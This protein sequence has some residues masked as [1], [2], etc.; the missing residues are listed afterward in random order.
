MSSL[1]RRHEILL[2]PRFKEDGQGVPFFTDRR[3]PGRGAERYYVLIA[4]IGVRRI[5]PGTLLQSFFQTI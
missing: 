1:L 2:S 4:S 5:G 3:L